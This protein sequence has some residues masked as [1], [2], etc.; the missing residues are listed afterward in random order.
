MHEFIY[1]RKSIRKFKPDLIPKEDIEACLKAASAAP[2]GKNLQNWHFVVVTNPE[3]IKKVADA[4]VEANRLYCSYTSDE[5]KKEMFRNSLSYQTLFVGAPVLILV[6]ASPYA[7][8]AAGLLEDKPPTAAELQKL[9]RH[10]PGIQN[11][12]AT[13]QNLLLAAAEMGYGTCWMTGP[14]FAEESINAA[15]GFDKDDFYLACI[16]PLGVP[17]DTK[18]PQ[19]PRKPL[20]ETVTWIE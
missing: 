19:P 18:H 13:M 2:S 17:E 6:Y 1:R 20:E 9:L 10:N 7:V 15:I 3:K 16:T 12:G 5:T 8:T 14:V 4:V 11:I